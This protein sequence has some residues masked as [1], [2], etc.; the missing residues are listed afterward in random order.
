MWQHRGEFSQVQFGIVKIPRSGGIVAAGTAQ[1]ASKCNSKGPTESSCAL[2]E[3][4][5]HPLADVAVAAG[6]VYVDEGSGDRSVEAAYVDPID[7]IWIETA[8]KL[9]ITV[10]RS[11]A[12]FASWNGAGELTLSTTAGFDADDCVA[13]LV[14]HEVCHALVEGPAAWSRPDWG[15]ENIDERDLSREHAAQRLQG[16]LATP[17][18]LRTL[19]APTTKWR[20]YYDALPDDPLAGPDDD[21]AVPLAQAAWRRS[22]EEPWFNPLQRA[23]EATAI[24]ARAV[25]PFASHK[26]LWRQ[27]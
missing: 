19:L 11:D 4:G 5:A 15:L 18:G 7:L 12:T 27:V 20:S 24:I 14:L 16:R 21:P 9:G 10:L 3:E 8:G 17:H 13:Q 26:T 6:G 25:A 22:Q 23:L 2:G 1:S